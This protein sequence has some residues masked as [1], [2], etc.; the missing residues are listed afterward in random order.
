MLKLTTFTGLLLIGT[1]VCLGGNPIKKLQRTPS[2]TFTMDGILL[3][4]IDI[5]RQ[6]RDSKTGRLICG[7]IALSVSEKEYEELAKIDLLL[8]TSASKQT[9][10]QDSHTIETRLR[11]KVAEGD[12]KSAEITT[13]ALP[14]LAKNIGQLEQDINTINQKLLTIQ[15]S[16]ITNLQAKTAAK[17]AATATGGASAGAGDHST[18]C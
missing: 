14:D 13:K 7:A 2:G 17:I 3:T 15:I 11:K 8:A 16:E 12:A 9:A 18:S 5:V 10:L 1:Q 6:A 4:S